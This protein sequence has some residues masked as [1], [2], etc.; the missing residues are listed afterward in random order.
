MNL[1]KRKWGGY[2]CVSKGHQSILLNIFENLWLIA[3]PYSSIYGRDFNK[4]PDC[5]TLTQF[6]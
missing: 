1:T 4:K 3:D 6:M 2:L 5:P